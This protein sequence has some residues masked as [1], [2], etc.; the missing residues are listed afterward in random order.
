MKFFRPTFFLQGGS[1]CQFACTNEVPLF[2]KL[3][4]LNIVSEL[5]GSDKF[6]SKSYAP[7]PFSK[8]TL[9]TLEGMRVKRY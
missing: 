1:T 2:D 9:D 8:D 5:I 7:T 6:I 3:N 4:K